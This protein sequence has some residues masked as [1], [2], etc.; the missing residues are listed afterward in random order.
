MGGAVVSPRWVKLARVLDRVLLIV[1]AG[2]QFVFCF[3]LLVAALF[4]AGYG[5]AAESAFGPLFFL[6]I[7]GLV[8]AYFTERGNSGVRIFG[9]GWNG[10][11]VATSFLLD[12]GSRPGWGK[13]TF[14]AFLSAL[15]LA[16]TVLIVRK[17]DTQ[18]VAPSN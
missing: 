10:A 9:A 14:C 8:A 7:T 17:R 5:A 16:A 12:L 6:A 11:F 15:Y 13:I 4:S 3:G 2:P 18:T 1:I